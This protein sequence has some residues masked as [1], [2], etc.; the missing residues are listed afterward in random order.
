MGS[1][2]WLVVYPEYSSARAEEEQAFVSRLCA[3][4]FD[5]RAFGIP[6][7][8]GWL[9]FHELDRRHRAGDRALREAYARLLR[10][11]DDRDVLVAAGGA[12]LHPELLDGLS[13]LKLLICADDPENSEHLSRPIAAHFDHCFVVNAAHVADYATW[14]AKGASWI[15]PVLRPERVDP[16]QN[17]RRILYGPRDLDIVL[18]CD[19]SFGIGD[20]A[21]RA[22]RLVSAFPQAHV[23]GRGWP[24]GPAAQS[25]V[26][27]LYT[28]SKIG[29]NLHHSTGPCNTRLL[30]LPANGVLQICDNQRFL[31]PIFEL[32]REI[33]GFDTI[34]E[35][36]EKTRHYLA[37][38]D[39]RR[40]IAAA[41]RERAMRDYTEER[42]W[43]RVDAK[44]RELRAARADAGRIDAQ[45]APTAA[46]HR[47][48]ERSDV[49]T[50]AAAAP[51]APGTRPKVWLLADKRGW[52]YDREAQAMARHLAPEFECRVAYVQ[53]KTDLASWDFDL[54]WVFFWGET[55]HQQFVA[56]PRRVVKMVGSHRWQNEAA[57]GPL[58]PASF[59]E[60]HLADAANCAAISERLRTLVQTVRSCDLAPQGVDLDVFTPSPVEPT[61]ALRTGWA[62][63]RA[64]ACKGVDDVLV[65]ACSGR[66]E[67]QIAGGDV[68]PTAMADFY[69]GLDVLCVASSAEGGPLPLIEALACGAFVVTTD[70][71][72]AREVVRHGDNGL[73]VARDPAAF[74]AALHWCENN[75]AFL[76][77]RRPQRATNLA[78]I[79]SWQ[80]A[81]AVR[82]E[83]L[84][85][86]MAQLQPVR[87]RVTA[88]QSID[89]RAM[90]SQPIAHASTRTTTTHSGAVA[91]ATRP[92]TATA[93]PST[94]VEALHA[95]YHDHLG[96]VSGA[97]EQTY[98]AASAYYRAELA[99]VLPQA[100]D[101]R[102]AEVGCGFG[103]LLR[104]L[105][106]RGYTDLSGCDLDPQ[107]A[108][109]TAR[110]L[111]TRATVAHREAR[112]F[113]LEHPGE[114]DLVLAFDILEHFDLEG[115]YA[116]AAAARSALRPGG[117]AVFRTPNMANVLGG[118]S[119]FMDLTH[120][121]GFTEQ[122][123]GQLLRAAGF[124]DLTVVHPQHEPGPLR[125]AQLQNQ[126]LH[127]QLFAQQDRSRPTCFDKNLVIAA[128]AP[129]GTVRDGAAR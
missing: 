11:L 111:A 3:R 119:R 95:T 16:R 70:V 50:S 56:D 42:M 14:G 114:F 17:E 113:L 97:D 47:F 44:A 100:R 6:C 65:P 49:I 48:E 28:R 75:L 123:A 21:A 72:I 124:V 25:E 105:A 46:P 122:S 81:C 76:R 57:Y 23:R 89:A 37:Y 79:R 106:E 8:G 128:R 91:V 104:F 29:W 33:V 12:M 121:I 98:R 93:A 32:D 92:D 38:D 129:R 60:R 82:A 45:R 71:G 5:A 112:A 107:L 55:W 69:R 35:C 26:V 7:E 83:T 115:A 127:E 126:K 9:P 101:A 4:G 67:L 54:V 99:A 19:R 15:P 41:G 103:H 109:A 66:F 88:T 86:A 74:R 85:A 51:V 73:I 116:F 58:D 30:E 108:A 62:G 39:E 118:Y 102:I 96:A 90:Q 84:R 53:E 64:D 43:D 80:Q 94:L 120:R 117:L 125:D 36:I 68:P 52:A 10:E 1:L 2:R 63:N 34:E 78:A 40:R 22:E 31:G 24:L 87:E 18:C 59:A 13:Q 61:G 27:E 20:R 110:R 77:S